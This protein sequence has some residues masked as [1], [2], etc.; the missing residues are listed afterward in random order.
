MIAGLRAYAE[1]KDSGL[2][3][4]GRVPAHWEEKRGKYFFC[5]VD[6]RSAAGDEQLLSVSHVTGVSPRKA[7]VTMFMAESNAGHKI[8]RPGDLVVNTMWAW[9]GAMGVSQEVGLVSPSYGVYRPRSQ[10][11]YCAD[12]LDHL[13]RTQPYVSEYVSRS[14]GIRASRLRLYPDE[15]LD[16]RVIRPPME[17]QN[18]IVRFITDKDRIVRRFIRNRRRLIEVLNQQKQAII[19]RAVTRGLDPNVSLK[20]SGIDWLGC[21]PEHWP[22]VSLRRVARSLDGQRVPLNAEERGR[23]QGEYAYWGANTIIDH[24]DQYL[25]DEDLVL[26][27]EDGAPFFDRIRDVAFYVSGKVWVNNHA[28]VLRPRGIVPRFL[29]HVLNCVDYAEYVGGAT[30]DKLTQQA[31]KSIPIQLPP[32]DEQE[33]ICSFIAEAT[34][35]IMTSIGKAQREIELI[36]EYRTRLITDVVTG[37]LDVRHLTSAEPLLADGRSDQST[38]AEELV[39]HEEPERVEEVTDAE[40]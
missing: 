28:H 6:E 31:M 4:L 30:R 16:I 1:Y 18:A 19:N 3:W 15:F 2:P 26:L 36:R 29:A 8:C 14:T 33:S 20:P 37:K 9:M 17:E 5:E 34:E 39:G 38:R 35:P 21:I 12:Y 32:H 7:N 27:G 23:M 40:D 22:L 13:F 11:L 25:F 10:E 24:V